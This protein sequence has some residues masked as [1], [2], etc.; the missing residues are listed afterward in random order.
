MAQAQSGRYSDPRE[1]KSAPGNFQV[2]ILAITGPITGQWVAEVFVLLCLFGAAC[3]GLAISLGD[4]RQRGA[5][6]PLEQRATERKPKGRSDDPG[7]FD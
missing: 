3:I 7:R 4:P 5:S 2:M 1:T 6:R